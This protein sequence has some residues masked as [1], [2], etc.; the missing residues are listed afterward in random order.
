[1]TRSKTDDT[2]DFKPAIEIKGDGFGF[3]ADDPD[4]VSFYQPVIIIGQSYGDDVG[5]STA[6]SFTLFGTLTSDE[7]QDEPVIDAEWSWG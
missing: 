3:M 5:T 1:M 6:K 4:D 2:F 7:R